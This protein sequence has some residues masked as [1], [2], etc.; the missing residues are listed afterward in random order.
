MNHPGSS[1]YVSESITYDTPDSLEDGETGLDASRSGFGIAARNSH[2]NAVGPP[3]HHHFP[4]PAKS[5]GGK[6]D[7]E[8]VD[9]VVVDNNFFPST[10]TGSITHSERL[11]SGDGNAHS[12]S[13]SGTGEEK[14]SQG[15]K[16]SD[17]IGGLRGNRLGWWK[18]HIWPKVYSFFDSV[19]ILSLFALRS[20]ANVYE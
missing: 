11:T 4:H 19:S 16:M 8:Q 12:G 13:R 10:R 6:E 17:G 1:S 18:Y 7:E 15:E 20:C 9:Q 3:L 14:E 2:Y 5:I